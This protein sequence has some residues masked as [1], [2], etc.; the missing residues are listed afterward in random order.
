MNEV[1]VEECLNEVSNAIFTFLEKEGG[2][3]NGYYTYVSG[4]VNVRE[5]EAKP[6]SWETPKAKEELTQKG[7]DVRGKV[8]YVTIQDIL[9]KHE[10]DTITIRYKDE[11]YG[12]MNVEVVYIQETRKKYLYL[13]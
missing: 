12:A 9:K 6:L 4:I 5:E 7:R 10:V 11:G 8:L 2:Y 1:I 3:N 13:N